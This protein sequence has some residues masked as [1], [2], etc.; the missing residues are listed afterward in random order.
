MAKLILPFRPGGRNWPTK[1]LRMNGVCFCA[2][3]YAAMARMI[4]SVRFI[5]NRHIQDFTRMALISTSRGQLA[6]RDL[7]KLRE[8]C[9]QVL[10]N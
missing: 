4:G 5:V 10:A 8:Y 3:K 7:E 1:P 9:E 6:V 2:R